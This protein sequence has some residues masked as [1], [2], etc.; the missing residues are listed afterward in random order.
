[1]AAEPDA[2]PDTKI[3]FQDKQDLMDTVQ[4][5][6]RHKFGRQIYIDDYHETSNGDLIISLGSSVPKDVSDCRERDNVLKFINLSQVHRLRATS[7]GGYYVI[8]LPE[9]S[10]IYQD[11]KLRKQE[12]L[13]RLDL[14]MART[15]YKRL[16]NL[17]SILNQLQPVYQ[18]LYWTRQKSPDITVGDV[19]EAQRTGNT[20]DYLKFLEE[21][22]YISI[23][24][25][26]LYQGE[27]LDIY[28]Y[29]EMGKSEFAEAVLG[30]VVQEGYSTLRDR[31]SLTMLNHYPKFSNG[32][33][34]TALQREDPGVWLD[35]DK[36]TQNLNQEYG[37]SIHQLELETKLEDLDRV[38]VIEK[39]DGFVTGK[40]DI[41]EEVSAQVGAL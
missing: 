10:E 38:G 15:I 22:G 17:P 2:S 27:K 7:G 6:L 29:V 23:E 21:L 33:Y 3:K 41:Y 13:K 36:I 26:V 5:K 11:Y 8:D 14:H 34:Y 28:D 37:E 12:M 1:M 19:K 9:K 30:D 16:T 31:F 20:E 32:Y 18:I 39:K 40:E 25:G 24:D 35:I 4:G